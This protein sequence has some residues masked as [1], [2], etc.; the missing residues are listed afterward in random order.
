[1]HS[2]RFTLRICPEQDKMPAGPGLN[3]ILGSKPPCQQEM[4]STL[5]LLKPFVPMRNE[6]VNWQQIWHKSCPSMKWF[7]FNLKK[8]LKNGQPHSYCSGIKYSRLNSEKFGIETQ[9]FSSLLL[10]F[11]YFTEVSLFFINGSKAILLPTIL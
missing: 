11:S 6:S 5:S 8:Y 7:Y 4:K 2:I 9:F 1:M 3:K 10:S